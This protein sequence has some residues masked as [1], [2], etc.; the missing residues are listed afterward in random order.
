MFDQS[1][2]NMMDKVSSQ[3][4]NANNSEAKGRVAVLA[5]RDL[6]GLLVKQFS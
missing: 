2:R 1:L 6:L 3:L 4:K 5:K